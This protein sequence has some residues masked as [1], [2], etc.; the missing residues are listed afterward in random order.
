IGGGLL[1]NLH[2]GFW[3]HVHQHRYPD[4]VWLPDRVEGSGDVRAALFFHPY[5]RFHQAINGC[6]LT[7]VTTSETA[8]TIGYLG[9]VYQQ[10]VPI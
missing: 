9:G 2:K 4:G 6:V 5:F 10:V 7:N 8:P 1:A 3:I